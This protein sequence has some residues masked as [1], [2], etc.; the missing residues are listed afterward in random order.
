MWI[1][2]EIVLKSSNRGF[3]LIT[4][5]ILINIPELKK[6]KIGLLNILIKAYFSLTNIK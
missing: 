6:I 1:Q 3:H 4:D 5:E 2:K